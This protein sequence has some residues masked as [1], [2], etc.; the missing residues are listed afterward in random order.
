DDGSLEE[1]FADLGLGSVA[2][3]ADPE[4]YLRAWVTHDEDSAR[5]P[6]QASSDPHSISESAWSRLSDADSYE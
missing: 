4:S 6:S 1:S 3:D 2:T 5:A